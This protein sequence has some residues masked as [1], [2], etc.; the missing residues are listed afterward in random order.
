MESSP[1]IQKSSEA[2]KCK[3]IGFNRRLVATLIDGLILFTG[4]FLLVLA[5]GLIGVYL[6]IY[7]NDEMIPVD[8]L[9]VICG[10]LLSI[11]YYVGTWSKR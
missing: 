9:A 6:N 2:R 7:S 11:F 5:V 4:T 3:V 8:R 1:F 10:L